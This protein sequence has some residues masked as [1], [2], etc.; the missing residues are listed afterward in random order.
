MD[1]SHGNVVRPF[2]LE[3]KETL[4]K[5]LTDKQLAWYED[6][7]NTDVEFCKRNKVRHDLL[8]VA[9]SVNPGLFTMIKRMA[10]EKY[11]GL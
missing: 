9:L 11:R 2:L 5:I 10:I 7:S 1:Y 8:P 3:R 6:P 4:L